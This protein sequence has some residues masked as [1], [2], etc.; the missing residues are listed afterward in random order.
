[1]PAH[2]KAREKLITWINSE[3]EVDSYSPEADWG[4]QYLLVWF[5]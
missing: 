3:T 1:M 5:D 2:G 4:Q